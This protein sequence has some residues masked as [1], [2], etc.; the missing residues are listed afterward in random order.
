[1]LHTM[2]TLRERLG[3]VLDDVR[4]VAVPVDLQGRAEHYWVLTG[5]AR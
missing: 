5:H 3:E 4:A 1:M 2:D